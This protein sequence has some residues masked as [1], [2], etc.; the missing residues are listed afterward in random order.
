M[1]PTANFWDGWGQAV[2]KA[3][4]ELVVGV[5]AVVALAFLFAKYGFPM[6]KEIKL[7][8]LALEEKR[9]DLDSKRQSDDDLRDKERIALGQAQVQA[10]EN[11]TRAMDALQTTQA[12]LVER[13]D[14]SAKASGRMGETLDMV[15]SETAHIP[16]MHDKLDEVYDRLV[17]GTD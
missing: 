4:P 1:Q 15:A 7:K 6:Y 14:G 5:V 11:M 13:I 16:D 9:I 2:T 12:V 17:G 10:Q 8:R 3:A